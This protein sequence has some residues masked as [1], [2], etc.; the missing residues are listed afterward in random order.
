MVLLVEV[1]VVLLVRR[2]GVRIAP[3]VPLLCW[4]FESVLWRQLSIMKVMCVA[5][6]HVV[7]ASALAGLRIG[8]RHTSSGATNDGRE[9]LWYNEWVWRVGA[10]HVEVE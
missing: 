1:S 2:R 5:I 7:V 9:Y 8:V 10:S 3:S 4:S 6:A